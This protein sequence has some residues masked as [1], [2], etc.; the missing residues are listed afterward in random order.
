MNSGGFRLVAI[1]VFSL[2]GQCG[3]KVA[4]N[5]AIDTGGGDDG[6]GGRASGSSGASDARSGRSNANSGQAVSSGNSGQAMSSTTGGQGGS[7]VM[8][9]AVVN[10]GGSITAGGLVTSSGSMG[11]GMM[12]PVVPIDDGWVSIDRNPFGIQG[13]FYV[14]DDSLDGGGSTIVRYDDGNPSRYCATGLAGQVRPG[15]DGIPAF[16]IYWGAAIGFNLFQEEGADTS[17]PYD[18]A[19]NGI[20]G[21]AFALDGPEVLPPDGELRFN[22]K[23]Y[24]DPSV[25]CARVAGAGI[26]TFLLSDLHQNCWENDLTA[27]TPDRTR[28]E[29]LQWQYVT[30]LSSSY[31][32]DTCIAGLAVF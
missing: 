17:L 4:S 30:N 2:L 14:F 3:G 10:S 18:A 9:A 21:F 28:L 1:L 15:A 27:P 26:S 23:V 31:K 16:D 32:F 8:A 5:G 11:N 6:T 19:A 7:G 24:G 13:A 29:S 12:L 25:Y 22:V 20:I